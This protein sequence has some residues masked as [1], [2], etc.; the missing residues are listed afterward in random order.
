MKQSASTTPGIANAGAR[1][2]LEAGRLDEALAAASAEADADPSNVEALYLKAVAERYLN[3]TQAALETVARLQALEPRFARAYQEEGHLQKALGD[4]ARAVA[5]Y[6]RAV[7]LNRALMASWR[8]LAALEAHRGNR[9]AQ[10]AAQ[11][12]YERLAELP[13]ELVS[14][15]SLFQEGKLFQAENLCRDFL[16][17]HPR[18]VEAMRLLARI[19]MKLFI[20]DDAEFLLESCVEFAPDNWLCRRDYVEILHKR[21]KFEQAAAQAAALRDRFPGN[22][23]FELSYA[24]ECVAVG[25]FDAALSIYDRVIERHGELE[26]PL[27][28]RGH[29]LKTVGRLDEAVAS[30]RN[31]S[32]ARAD[33]GDAFWSLA[34]LKTYRFTDEE[35]AAM[36]RYVDDGRTALT[37]RFQLSFA[38]GKAWEDR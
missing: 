5:A 9:A 3:R 20:Y 18:H 12:E 34:N 2:L 21:Q 22:P 16:R 36:E 37:D 38:L 15:T 24:N 6:R 31:A 32:R 10:Q 11:A 7:E 23:A 28:A 33:F 1:Q 25:R 35:I 26:Q 29:V 8:E 27:L 19:G 14:V 4:T 13:A 17:R 30:Y